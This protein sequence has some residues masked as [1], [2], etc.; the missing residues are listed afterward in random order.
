MGNIYLRIS[1]TAYLQRPIYLQ[2][3]FLRA[4]RLQGNWVRIFLI[5]YSKLEVD[6]AE[7]ASL[8][9]IPAQPKCKYRR[10]ARAN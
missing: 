1:L 9:L 4:V 10:D 8:S 7:S 2:P 5:Y 6:Y 3:L